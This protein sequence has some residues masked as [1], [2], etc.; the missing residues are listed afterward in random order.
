MCNG[1]SLPQA[2][3]V[4]KCWMRRKPFAT[5][6]IIQRKAFGFCRISCGYISGQSRNH[7]T[8][9]WKCTLYLI[10]VGEQNFTSACTNFNLRSGSTFLEEE[11]IELRSFKANC[12]EPVSYHLIASTL[13]EIVWPWERMKLWLNGTMSATS[14]ILEWQETEGE[15]M[16]EDN[17]SRQARTEVA[18]SLRKSEEENCRK[19]RTILPEQP[20]HGLSLCL[21]QI[22][23][24]ILKVAM[25]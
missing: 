21:N 13:G 24:N 22:R 3:Y 8:A 10:D 19:C 7:V 20:T 15:W 11:R 14:C 9:S 5:K 4:R 25:E 16:Q 23:C 18:V 1:F 2:P 17:F 6:Q 12:K